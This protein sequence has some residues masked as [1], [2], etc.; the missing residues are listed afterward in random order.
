MLT[1][2]FGG[3]G[4]REGGVLQ[5]GRSFIRARRLISMPPKKASAT[6]PSRR[7]GGMSGHFLL[8]SANCTREFQSGVC[9]LGG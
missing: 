6:G 9:L 3:K 8:D 4:G 1:G 2:V 7:E 5:C